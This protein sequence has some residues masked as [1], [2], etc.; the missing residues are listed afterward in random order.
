MQ[1]N[2]FSSFISSLHG[3][4]LGSGGIRFVMRRQML[5]SCGVDVVQHIWGLRA[6]EVHFRK[7]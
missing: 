2:N 1:L 5:R 7:Q 4:A 6:D 3:L